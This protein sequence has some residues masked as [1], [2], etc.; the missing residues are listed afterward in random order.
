MPS[1]S[2]PHSERP[3]DEELTQVNSYFEGNEKVI[4]PK[5][6]GKTP[7]ETPPEWRNPTVEQLAGVNVYCE[8]GKVVYLNGMP[9]PPKP[10]QP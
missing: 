5:T 8:G 9:D 10:E 6:D 4:L 3:N 7:V 1:E 2:N